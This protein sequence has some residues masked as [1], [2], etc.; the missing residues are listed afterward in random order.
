MANTTWNPTDISGVV[1]S[2]GNLTV[3]ASPSVG[4]VRAFNKQFIG[5]FYWECTYTTNGSTWDFGAG[6]CAGDAPLSYLGGG[7]NS[8]PSV[9][10]DRANG[11]CWINSIGNPCIGS[12]VTGG[13]VCIAVD[14]AN[15]LIWFRNG[16][17]GNWNGVANYTPGG[18]GGILY[19]QDPLN[20]YPFAGFSGVASGQNIVA[21]FGDSAFAGV[22]PVGFTAGFTADAN[23]PNIAA[24]TQ[25][26]F[27]QW[28][29]PFPDVQ[30]T[31]IAFEQ[32]GL[33][34]NVGTQAIL[35]QTALEEWIAAQP[36]S[37]SA[38]PY[39]IILV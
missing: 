16:A 31:Q 11:Y 20:W 35:T 22:V 12:I 23:P 27:E 21:N 1:L 9:T 28:A 29:Q 14:F 38:K 4:G 15:R 36:V 7:G 2:G 25:T 10:V 37:I 33:S 13:I 30:A 34:A 19:P 26:G 5:K 8:G 39:G 3:T 32:W 17:A 24:N 18:Y 6:I